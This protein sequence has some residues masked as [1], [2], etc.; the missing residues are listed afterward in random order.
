MTL[1]K[2]MLLLCV[3]LAI[4]AQIVARRYFGSQMHQAFLTLMTYVLLADTALI[5]SSMIRDGET[6]LSRDTF[7]Q[8]LLLLVAAVL[9]I[10]GIWQ[11][12]LRSGLPI[13]SR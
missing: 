6:S 2:V 4:V 7:L 11:G 9:V 3:A 5:F 13:W 12:L 1:R 8:P 10:L